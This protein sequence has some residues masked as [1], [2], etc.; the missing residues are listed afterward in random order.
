MVNNGLINSGVQIRIMIRNHLRRTEPQVLLINQSAIY[1]HII[2]YTYMYVLVV[3]VQFKR[4]YINVFERWCYRRMLR[5]SW[6]EHVT[7]EEV[8]NRANTKP[9]LLDGLL[10]RRLAFHGHLVRKGGITL[11][12]MIGRLHGTRPRG[13][14]RTTWLK[15]LATQANISYKEAMTIPRDRKKWRSVGNPRRTPDEWVSEW[16]TSRMSAISQKIRNMFYFY[17]IARHH[18]KKNTFMLIFHWS[19]NHLK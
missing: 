6:T 2:F 18:H 5:I 13:R 15:D 4:E 16:V 12:L 1:F 19:I 14:P 11:D 8:F 3:V 7:N 9:T 17:F 10:K